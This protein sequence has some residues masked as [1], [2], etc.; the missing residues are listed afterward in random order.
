MVRPKHFYIRHLPDILQRHGTLINT[1][2]HERK[3][4]VCLRYLRPRCTIAGFERGVMEDVTCHCIWDVT[5]PFLRLQGGSTPRPQGMA[6]LQE[7]CPS[8]SADAF[9]MH[10]RARVQRGEAT[11]KDMVICM[12]DNRY[13]VGQLLVLFPAEGNCS[14]SIAF[15]VNASFCHRR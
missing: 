2:M 4:R 8:I 9:Q 5:Q 3:H 7:L 11:N 1:L 15:V 10:A 12:L 14:F 6:V 13:R